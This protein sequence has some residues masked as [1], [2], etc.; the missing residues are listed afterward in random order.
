MTGLRGKSWVLYGE[1]P[2]ERG[3]PGGW[4]RIA[5]GTQTTEAAK[6]AASHDLTILLS[7]H[8]PYWMGS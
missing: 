5:K 1:G 4:P 7:G 3:L 8:H 2:T 6:R